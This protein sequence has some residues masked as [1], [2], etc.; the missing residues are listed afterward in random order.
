MDCEIPILKVGLDYCA[1]A[2][3]KIR[4]VESFPVRF[5]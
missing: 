1:G 3:I 2:H 5:Y 4:L